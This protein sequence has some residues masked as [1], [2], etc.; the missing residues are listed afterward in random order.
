MNLNRIEPRHPHA[1]TFIQILQRSSSFFFFLFFIKNRWCGFKIVNDKVT[2][3]R[4]VIKVV[5]RLKEKILKCLFF[6]FVAHKKKVKR[7]EL[8]V[9]DLFL[10]TSVKLNIES[11]TV[12]VH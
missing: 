6:K 11:G 2:F 10:K 4:N 1:F 8:K 9:G 12:R 7:K 5:A 3:H